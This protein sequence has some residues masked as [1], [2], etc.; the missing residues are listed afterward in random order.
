MSPSATSDLVLPTKACHNCRKRRWKCDRSLPVCQKCLSTGVDCLGYGKLFVWN[1]G[2]AS[3][4]KMMGKSFE[5]RLADR[6]VPGNTKSDRSIEVVA[7]QDNASGYADQPQ[8]SWPLV[9]PLVQDL[10]PHSRYYIHHFST[11]ICEDLVVYDVPGQNPMRELISAITAHPSLLQIILANSAFHVFNISSDPESQ[12]SYQQDQKPC[13][14]AYYRAVGRFGGPM[15]SSYRDALLAKQQ[16]LS[17]LA[18]GIASVNESNIDLLLVVILFFINYDL[19]ES[20][21]D[22]WK[23]HM[24]GAQKIINLLATPRFIQRPMSRLRLHVLSDLLVFYVLGS[25]FSFSTMPKLI[26]DS[27]DLEPIL[28]YAETN[29]YLSCPSP[30]LRIMIQSFE[31]PDTRKSL[32]DEIATHVQEQ[33]GELLVA[34]LAFDP[35]H[36]THNFEPASPFENLEHRMR[37]ASAHRAAVCIYLARVLPATN[38]LLDPSKGSALV[39]LTGLANEIVFHISHLKP[40]DIMFKSISWALFMAGA[41]SEDPAQRTWIMNTMDEFY[42]LLYWGYIRTVKKVLEAIWSRKDKAAAGSDNCWVDEVQEMGH[43]MLIA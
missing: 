18:E 31:L 5:E 12:S 19:I 42:N 25:T 7:Q 40:G 10:S 4:G 26:P 30:L 20:G 22:K 8:L 29:N 34:A 24:D 1:K 17:L 35:V 27:I 14:V 41:E 38:P 6:T 36:W 15:K 13:L 43:E 16:A 11:Q 2:V 21:K 3:R 33:V 37:I 28:R 39:S 23:V 32:A 9:D